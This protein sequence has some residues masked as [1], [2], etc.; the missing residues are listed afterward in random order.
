MSDSCQCTEKPI[1][2]CKVKKIIKSLR[3][4]KNYSNKVLKRK[5]Q[6]KSVYGIYSITLILL[7]TISPTSFLDKHKCKK[8]ITYVGFPGGASGKEPTAN[9]GDIR[10]SGSIP[11]LGKPLRGEHG[12]PLQYSCPGESHGHRRLVGYSP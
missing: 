8:V 9:A 11:G 10:D 7:Y 2:Y 1:Q 3:L 4:K 12:N 5:Q 6:N